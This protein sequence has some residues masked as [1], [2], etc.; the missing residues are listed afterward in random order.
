MVINHDELLDRFKKIIKIKTDT[1]LATSLNLS[2]NTIST[3][4]SRKTVDLGLIVCF[5]VERGFDLNE[6]FY[7]DNNNYKDKHTPPGIPTN[8]SSNEQK[9]NRLK[10]QILEDEIEKLRLNIEWLMH[11]MTQISDDPTLREKM[12]DDSKS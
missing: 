2:R 1:E 5:C 3:W 10:F 6:V 4:R 8:L 11:K 7:G 9:L 12:S